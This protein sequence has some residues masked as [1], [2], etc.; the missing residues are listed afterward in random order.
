VF[1]F[2]VWLI[3]TIALPCL[4]LWR[5]LLRRGVRLSDLVVTLPV[6]GLLAGG[7]PAALGLIGQASAVASLIVAVLV[8]TGTFWGAAVAQD[9]GLRGSLSRLKLLMLGWVG[10]PCTFGALFL[11]ATLLVEAFSGDA[12]AAASAA[13]LLLLFGLGAAPI[14][15]MDR[16]ARGQR[17]RPSA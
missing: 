7:L 5:N 1:W 14:W 12:A 10:V 17:A 2:H 11:S 13:L 3:V 8:L 16:R 15:M 9:L 4:V 6:L